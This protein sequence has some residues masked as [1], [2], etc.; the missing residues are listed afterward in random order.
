M[1]TVVS[2]VLGLAALFGPQ[3]LAMLSPQALAP[4]R[5]AWS[6]CDTR[7]CRPVDVSNLRLDAPTT[8]LRAAYRADG[9]SSV[10][11]LAVHVVAT[12]SADVFWNGAPIGANGRVG[13]DRAHEVPG[14]FSAVIPVPQGHVRPGLNLVE[15]RLSAHHL[16]AP[17]VRP[18]HRLSVEPYADP[19]RRTLSHYLPI[20]ALSGLLAFAFIA[21]A[22]LWIVRQRP[23]A[24]ILAFMSGAV[25]AQAAVEASKL[26][27]TYAYPW[28][29]AR[30]MAIAG[31]TALA[32]FLL[33]RL[34]IGRLSRRSSRIWLTV[35]LA[36]ALVV[37]L[38]TPPWWDA[39]AL[40]CFRAGLTTVWLAAA[41]GTRSDA[42]HLYGVQVGCILW[43]ALSWLPGFL[44]HLYYAFYL[45]LF[46]G[47]GLRAV[48]QPASQTAEAPRLQQKVISV[49][50][51]TSRHL[52]AADDILSARAADD[53]SLVTLTDG[54]ELLATINLSSLIDLAPTC[55]QRIHRSHAVN[56]A[57]VTAVHRSDR[58][59]EMQ[60]GGRIP[61]GRTYWTKFSSI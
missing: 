19:L 26:A 34:A 4:D 38:A 31:L 27:L 57:R 59:M 18:I 55:L 50:N 54:R 2:A 3:V 60:G 32:A 9:A 36:L 41:L 15:V 33:G 51:G 56:P 37:A 23:Q 25:L 28:Q 40:W 49:P 12:A 48:R 53:Y 24:A 39:K 29:L 43:L 13:A 52:I 17:V 47:L 8:T 22:G 45:L 61:V 42:R 21:A 58:T 20:L 46:C 30:L 6:L 35:G 44:D 1:I 16:W 14:S 10:T 5:M 11:P 7:G